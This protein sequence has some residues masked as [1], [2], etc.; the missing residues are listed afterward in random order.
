MST[1]RP[2]RASK[3]RAIENIKKLV[4]EMNTYDDNGVL[5]EE[6]AIPRTGSSVEPAKVTLQNV[7]DAYVY[8]PHFVKIYA[9]YPP[10]F[11][12]NLMEDDVRI[13]YMIEVLSNIVAGRALVN[14]SN[15]TYQYVIDYYRNY[16]K[17]AAEYVLDKIYAMEEE[18]F[19]PL[20][21]MPPIPPR[22]AALQALIDAH[23]SK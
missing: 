2:I 19:G 4:A 10:K 12:D 23:Y 14:A 1:S 13:D 17:E 22:S 16:T 20:D 7:K 21:D 11:R 3:Q 8:S 15:K 18:C 6:D 9:L 5:C